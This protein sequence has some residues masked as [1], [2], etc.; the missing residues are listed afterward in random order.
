MSTSVQEAVKDLRRVLTYRLKDGDDCI[1][2]Q[3]IKNLRL[4]KDLHG[5]V[6]LEM[7]ENFEDSCILFRVFFER[8]SNPQVTSRR[9]PYEP[10]V[11]SNIFMAVNKFK[12]RLNVFKTILTYTCR[13]YFHYEALFAVMCEVLNDPVYYNYQSERFFIL[14]SMI[15]LRIEQRRQFPPKP[16][17]VLTYLCEE[18]LDK[19]IEMMFKKHGMKG[20]EETRRVMEFGLKYFNVFYNEKYS[21]QITRILQSDPK[22]FET[23]EP[24]LKKFFSLGVRCHQ[25]EESWFIRLE[26][27]FPE[28]WIAFREYKVSYE[29][30]SW[31]LYWYVRH[32][33]PSLGSLSESET[34]SELM[35]RLVQ[36]G[37]MSFPFRDHPKLD[38]ALRWG[39]VQK[40]DLM[41][42]CLRAHVKSGEYV[43]KTP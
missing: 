25:K 30:I 18:S 12:A 3:G 31:I 7:P 4:T 16:D 42:I 22:F 38:F 26:R 35:T 5:L 11:F 1:A 36:P 2:K 15:I 37:Q 29:A 39:V 20:R 28:F 17:S 33:K 34:F 24:A 23:W 6:I 13:E 21:E 32:T 41:E 8:I 40:S 10:I 19:I 43:E 9:Y 14:K 27:M